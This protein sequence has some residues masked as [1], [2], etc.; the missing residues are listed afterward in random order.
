MR[1]AGKFC[2]ELNSVPFTCLFHY[3][4]FAVDIHRTSQ[5]HV[6]VQTGTSETFK[7]LE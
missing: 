4:T 2:A 6:K 1:N 5:V 7:G 3:V